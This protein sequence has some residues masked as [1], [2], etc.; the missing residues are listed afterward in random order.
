MWLINT[1]T[2]CLEQVFNPEEEKYAILSHTWGAEEVSLQDFAD[3]E[4]RK[5][6]G[7]YAKIKKTCDLA[8]SR[9][10]KYAWVDTCCIDKTSS[11]ELSEA[12]NSMFNWY[13]WSTVCFAVIEDLLPRSA[14]RGQDDWLSKSK[15]HRW[16][17]RGWTLQELIAP[18]RVTGIDQSILLDSGGLSGLPVAR[19]MSWASRR[20][21]TRVEDMSYCLLGIFDVNMPLLYGEG[22][23]AFIRLQ[24][25][26]AKETNDLSLF[27]WVTEQPTSGSPQ[28]FPRRGLLASSPREFA[29]CGKLK[30]FR[31]WVD[32]TQDKFSVTNN[33]VKMTARVKE[34]GDKELV[35]SLSCAVDD[36]N[37]ETGQREW[38]SIYL[39]KTGF[40]KFVRLNPEVVGLT[41]G[42]LLDGDY[43]SGQSI[44]ARFE[45]RTIYIHKF[46]RPGAPELLPPEGR[47]HFI[48][49]N[50]WSRTY[51]VSPQTISPP[52]L[53]VPEIERLGML[54][55]FI[56]GA[57]SHHLDAAAEI[58]F[59]F[60]GVIK[61]SI[62]L[63]QKPVCNCILV[64]GFFRNSQS[65]LRPVAVVYS[66]HDEDDYSRVGKPIFDAVNQRIGDGIN[67]ADF[68]HIRSLV[69]ANH[70][71]PSRALEWDDVCDRVLKLSVP[72][73]T[74]DR[75]V[76]L[77]LKIDPQKPQGASS[78][79][80]AYTVSICLH[81]A[82][83]KPPGSGLSEGSRTST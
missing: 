13:R 68:A 73:D 20:E 35:M 52:A 77:F 78:S 80:W 67:D 63:Y 7:G 28:T 41:S 62:N 49:L 75:G 21:T 45:R 43:A 61:F 12:I 9:G 37:S 31:S 18:K 2:M 34:Q 66:D 44:W 76:K 46:L 48:C 58:S 42:Y 19:R 60:T 53:W 74:R 81:S 27:A 72:P 56:T 71:V 4:K 50:G 59:P 36:Q 64:C 39:A 14:S 40:G 54:G 26:I 57:E 47:I 5:R 55:Y 16:F 22:Y 82:H 29:W 1:T 8:K 32:P 24:E 51:S 10:L 33:G 3:P 38:V 23:R 30:R 6:K 25:E 70:S 65:L 17:T 11:A 15:K 83:Q 79:S 69:V